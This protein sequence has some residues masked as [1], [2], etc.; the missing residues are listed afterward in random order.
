[1]PNGESSQQFSLDPVESRNMAQ[2]RLSRV[3]TPFLSP[4][5]LSLGHV[6]RQLGAHVSR[7]LSLAEHCKRWHQMFLSAAVHFKTAKIYPPNTM[8]RIRTAGRFDKKLLRPLA[9]ILLQ[10]R[11]AKHASFQAPEN[12][13]SYP[14]APKSSQAGKTRPVARCSADPRRARAQ[15]PPQPLRG[16]PERLLGAQPGPG[17]AVPRF[18]AVGFCLV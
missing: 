6:S 2:C 8:H 17:E 15:E 11:L 16:V 1:M 7:V 18:G 10:G 4:F 13:A 12:A 5:Y 3:W 9:L 14:N